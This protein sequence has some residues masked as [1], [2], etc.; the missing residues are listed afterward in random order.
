MNIALFGFMG[1]GKSAVGR[2]LADR[3]GFTFVDLDDEIVKR[4]GKTISAIFE[5]EGEASFREVEKKVTKEYAFREHQVIACGG[6]TVLDDDNLNRLRASSTLILLTADPKIIS[7]RVAANGETR[8]LLSVDNRLR[9]ID[10][11]LKSRHPRYIRAA[12]F[13]VDVSDGTPEEIAEDII[14]SLEGLRL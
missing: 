1:V 9:R 14:L 4:K 12:D 13:V 10:S 5:E 11:L 3:V 8:P 7:N 6:G 2:I